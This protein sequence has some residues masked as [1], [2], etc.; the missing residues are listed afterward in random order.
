M[1]YVKVTS[2]AHG[3]LSLKSSNDLWFY[4][5]ITL[6]LMALTYM[7]VWVRSSWKKRRRRQNELVADC[8][9]PESQDGMSGAKLESMTS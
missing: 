1:G 7:M 4:A 3:A 6:P 9:V 8:D 5:T 2:T